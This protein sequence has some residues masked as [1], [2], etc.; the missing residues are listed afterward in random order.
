[1]K[2]AGPEWSASKHSL[3]FASSH[4]D[5]G[6]EREV[7]HTSVAPLLRSPACVQAQKGASPR[8]SPF[9]SVLLC[10]GARPKR[11]I[12]QLAAR[13]ARALLRPKAWNICLHLRTDDNYAWPGP[14]QSSDDSYMA[15]FWDRVEAHLK[16]LLQC[17]RVRGLLRGQ[18]W[19]LL[20]GWLLRLLQG[21]LLGVATG[22]CQ[23]VVRV[24]CLHKKAFS[25]GP[26]KKERESTGRKCKRGW[27]V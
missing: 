23:L 27:D 16:P 19:K 12:L 26:Q 24:R 8:F 3:R 2:P 4:T 1:M 5:P 21:L 25:F 10:L 7:L 6:D 13:P 20:L 14:E 18:L 9:S 11:E 22:K 15:A 17:A